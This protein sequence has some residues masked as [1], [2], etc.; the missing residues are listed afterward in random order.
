MNW[1]AQVSDASALQVGVSVILNSSVQLS[2]M[3][4]T[5]MGCGIWVEQATTLLACCNVP[6]TGKDFVAFI[7]GT[8]NP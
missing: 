7:S 6:C 4:I 2:D 1:V 8:G 3:A 5:G